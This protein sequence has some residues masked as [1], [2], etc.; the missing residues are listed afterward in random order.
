MAKQ[1]QKTNNKGNLPEYKVNEEI[2]I[3][4]N[5]MV[6][7]VGQGIDAKVMHITEAR[8]LANSLELDMIL[9]NENTN[10]PILKIASYSKMMYELKKN[11]KK[12]GHN[13][14]SMKEIQLS[15][16]IAPN[17]IVTKVNKAKE[18]IKAGSKVKVVLSMKGREKLRRE[19]N[20]RSIYEFI[21]MLGD[22]AIPEA[23]PK[24]E[25]DNKT[26]VILK[27]KN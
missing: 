22:I 23:L 18:F 5:G 1:Q 12:Q 19:E 24:D 14:K 25:G 21:D 11:A 15:V 20:K 13:N 8:K 26:I 9:L 16:S 2:W 10:P 3:S 27:R 4:G 6:R 7:V 17:D